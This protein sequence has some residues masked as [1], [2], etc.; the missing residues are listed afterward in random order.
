MF[1]TSHFALPCSNDLAQYAELATVIGVVVGNHE[2]F[3][4]N[5]MSI[6]A[7]W[8]RMVEV[9]RGVLYQCDQFSKVGAELGDG[10]VPPGFVGHFV[11]GSPQIVGEDEFV[12][13]GVATVIQNIPLAD[14]QMFQQMPEGV[15]DIC[16]AGVDVCHREI[17]DGMVKG[18]VRLWLGEKVDELLA[19]V[20]IVGHGMLHSKTYRF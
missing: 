7:M 19:D 2:D 1:R 14:S 6:V 15:L 16:R 12:V 8:N 4:E 11:A 17:L 5:G 13:I 3:T 18:H 10:V 20:A 9:S